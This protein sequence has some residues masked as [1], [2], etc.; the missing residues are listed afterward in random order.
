MKSSLDHKKDRIPQLFNIQ[1]S[2]VILI[3]RLGEEKANE[4][5]KQP[6]TRP[7]DITGRPMKGWVMIA[8][9]GCQSDPDLKAW[10][11]QAKLFVNTLPKK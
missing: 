5:L 7:F 3:L 6:H 11:E 8:V 4:A 1:L 9:K 10:L 2:L